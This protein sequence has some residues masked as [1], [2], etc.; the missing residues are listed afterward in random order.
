M[1]TIDFT[2]TPEPDGIEV[3]SNSEEGTVTFV[4]DHDESNTA[5]P[6]EWITV[7]TEATVDLEQHR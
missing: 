7:E 2:P 1:S 4:A 6:T 5:A 3:L